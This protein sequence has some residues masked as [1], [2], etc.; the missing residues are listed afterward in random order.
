MVGQGEV[1][2]DLEPEVREECSKFGE[3]NN[4]LIYEVNEGLINSKR[5]PNCKPMNVPDD[6]AVRIFVEFNRVESAIKALV[7]L[8][9]RYFG[10]KVVKGVFY[11]L[12][13]F[14]RMDLS[15]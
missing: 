14:R 8:N 12:D 2:A 4:C 1:D 5:M 10:G 15:G 7:D 6:Q 3:V 9:G 13:K 11:D